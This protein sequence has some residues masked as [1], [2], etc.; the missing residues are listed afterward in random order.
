MYK[1]MLLILSIHVSDSCQSTLEPLVIM[2]NLSED[3]VSLKKKKSLE[4]LRKP[5]WHFGEKH[6]SHREC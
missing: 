2:Y 3:H 6:V 1:D 4:Y 5:R